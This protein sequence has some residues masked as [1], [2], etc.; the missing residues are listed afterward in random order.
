MGPHLSTVASFRHLSLQVNN[1]CATGSTALI[2]AKQLVEGG[3]ADCILALGFD[4]MQRGSLT[5]AVSLGRRGGG[6]GGG[7]GK[8]IGATADVNSC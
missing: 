3:V 4:K 8:L 2:L 7:N 1:A 5:S 6:G